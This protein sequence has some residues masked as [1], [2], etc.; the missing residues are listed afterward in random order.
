MRAD[1]LISILTFLQNNQRMTAGDL[2][3]RLEVSERTIYRDMEALGMAGIP[4]VA[5]R[6]VG[7]GWYLL[8]SYRTHLTGLNLAEIQALFVNTPQQLL[9]DLGLRE[10]SELALIKLL[11]NLPALQRQNAEFIRQRIHIDSSG[12]KDFNEDISA[13]PAL[14]EAIWSE[15]KVTLIYQR[16]DGETVERTLDP[17]GLVAKGSVWYL[18]AGVENDFRTYRVSRIDSVTMLDESVNRPPDFD[19]ATY[20]QQST[21]RF[22]ATL[23]RYPAKMRVKASMLTWVKSWRFGKI[24]SISAPDADGWIEVE[25]V[26]DVIEEACGYILGCGDQ[27]EVLEPAELRVRVIELAQS[28]IA[29]YGREFHI[30]NL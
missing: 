11:G 10:A 1:R 8:D 3:T 25:A 23:P 6:G 21:A 5:D 19:L 9:D 24:G 15:R 30:E 28:V 12:W 16:G 22:T 17:L 20:W 18:I 29:F 2:A 13:L 27:I 4:V 14:Q 26:F 7:G